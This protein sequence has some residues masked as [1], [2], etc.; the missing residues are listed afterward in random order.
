MKQYLLTHTKKRQYALLLGDILVLSVSILLSYAIRIYL[1]QEAPLFS[2]ILTR[3]DPRQIIVVLVHLLTLYLLNQY[4]LYRIINMV[5]SSVMIVLSVLLAGLVISGV[6]FFF[7]KYIFGRQ[8]LLIHII[9]VS[10][11]MVAWRALFKEVLIRRARPKRLA[12]VGNEQI[13]SSFIE[14]VSQLLH[15]GFR[16]NSICVS[17]DSKTCLY[18]NPL[19]TYNSVLELLDS[20]N[21]DALAFDATNGFI[22]DEESRRVLQV[23]YEGKAVYDLASLYEYLTGKVPIT[24]IDGRWL[25]NCD[26]LQG[27]TN[28]PYVQ[29]KRVIDIIMSMLL[30]FLFSPIII[31][32]AIAIKTSG[33]GKMLFVQERLGLHKKPFLCYKFRTMVENAEGKSGPVWSKENDSRIT[34]VGRILRKSRLDELPQLWNILKGDMSFVGPRPIREYFADSLSQKIPFYGFRFNVKPG[35]SGWAQVNH[36]YA[37]SD[38]GQFEKFQYELFYIKNMSFFL[39]VFT[40]LKTVREVLRGGGV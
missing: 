34:S 19:T 40:V 33:K 14:E 16:V 13:V 1:N 20:N 4:N 26:S 38:E 22:K 6:F 11:S 21:F 8:V 9:L 3:I 24:Y 12:V 10:I 2:T 31:I 35:L 32:I 7:P 27:E 37:G 39:D 28:R 25:L 23:K 17:N 36:D 18:S 30:L 29:A 5:R 15:S